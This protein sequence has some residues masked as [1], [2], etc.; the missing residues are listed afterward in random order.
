M[1]RLCFVCLGNVIRSPLAEY[2]FRSQAAQ[3]KVDHK[4]LVSSAATSNYRV[5]EPYDGRMRRVAAAHGLRYEGTAR[6]LLPED[7]E[8]NDL[9]LVMD[10]ENWTH[11]MSLARSPAQKAKVHLLRE[12]DPEGGGSSAVTDPYYGSIEGFEEVY[13]VVERSIIGLLQALEAGVI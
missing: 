12:F 4:Y 2:L 1:I 11:L 10:Y 5:G 7:L 9:I 6:Q 3:G 13:Q 8:L